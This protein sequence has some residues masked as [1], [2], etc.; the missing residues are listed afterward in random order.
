MDIKT[1]VLNVNARPTLVTMDY[2]MNIPEM[3]IELG[4]FFRR[5]TC[6]SSVTYNFCFCVETRIIPVVILP[7]SLGRIQRSPQR[8]LWPIFCSHGFR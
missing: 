5:F 4:I 7:A 3:G 1:S 2:I 8:S 6:Y